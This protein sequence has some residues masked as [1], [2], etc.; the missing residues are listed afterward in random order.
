[1]TWDDARVAASQRTFTHNGTPLTGH[2]VSLRSDGENF[3]VAHSITPADAWIGLTDNEA[4]G[5]T[6]AGTNP[7]G[8]WVWVSGEPFSYQKF[9]GG[10][11]NDVGGEDAVHVR[12]DGFWNDHQAGP[13]LGQG[14]HAIGWAVE[15]ETRA[16]S[17]PAPTRRLNIGPSGG[18]GFVGVREVKVGD[19]PQVNNLA[20]AIAL[21]RANQADPL[22]YTRFD[23]QAT[24]INHHDT[25]VDGQGGGGSFGHAGKTPFLSD[26]AGD[27]QDFVY[28]ANGVMRIPATGQYTFHVSSDDGFRLNI[29]GANFTVTASQLDGAGGIST[30]DT[31]HYGTPT[32]NANTFMS[33]TLAAGDHPFEFIF[34][35]RA[36]G[37]YVDLSSAP[38][39]HSSFDA[40][41]FRLVG[42]VAGGGIELVPEPTGLGLL[43]VGALGLLARRRRRQAA[44]QC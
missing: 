7:N 41:V 22:T 44:G 14:G 25:D 28:I 9:G 16:A 33:T 15:Y 36:G 34:F 20:D 35:E 19:P 21:L 37:A 6:E 24:R 31:V 38:G 29:E 3:F 1:M 23:G 13:T 17:N 11:P 27:D 43:G 40:G 4:R 26:A 2:L 39:S 30:G 12:G 5:G 32:G 42:D 10:E 8:G 18:N